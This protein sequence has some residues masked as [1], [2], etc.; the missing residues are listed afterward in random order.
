MDPL[1]HGYLLSWID[2][3]AFHDDGQA[4]SMARTG[5]GQRQPGTASNDAVLLPRTCCCE[6]LLF[7]RCLL[8]KPP[9]AC[10]FFTS[11]SACCKSC[12]FSRGVRPS[13]PPLG[14]ASSSSCTGCV[15]FLLAIL[16]L[17]AA[18]PQLNQ[19]SSHVDNVEFAGRFAMFEHDL[20]NVFNYVE[21]DEK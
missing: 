8:T 15:R 7:F 3:R 19:S 21:H 9:L 6:C 12:L 10:S 17:Q 16:L 20:C 2:V 5:C 11:A 14:N 18:P 13:R 1:A 4:I